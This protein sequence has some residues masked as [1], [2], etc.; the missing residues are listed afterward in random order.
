MLKPSLCPVG[1][2]CVSNEKGINID[3]RS[4]KWNARGAIIKIHS[5]FNSAY[6]ATLHCTKYRQGYS[7]TP[8]GFERCEIRLAATLA[9]PR[10]P[11]CP[12]TSYK[13]DSVLTKIHR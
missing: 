9:K 12:T 6:A 7:Q 8:V 10:P 1:A 3:V 13:T 11:I 2:V 4:P 5:I